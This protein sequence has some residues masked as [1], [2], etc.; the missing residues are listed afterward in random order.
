MD[1][2]ASLIKAADDGTGG[3]A[4]AQAGGYVCDDPMYA[5]ELTHTFALEIALERARQAAAAAAAAHGTAASPA[6]APASS[7]LADLYRR[8]RGGV[9]ILC[10]VHFDRD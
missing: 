7:S 9:S 6:P 5:T 2:W 3:G 10:A 1:R 4:G 8:V